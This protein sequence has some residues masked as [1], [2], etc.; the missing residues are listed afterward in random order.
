M[1]FVYP[2]FLLALGTLAIPILIHLFNFRRYKK[3]WF[4]NVQFLKEIQ[5]ETRKQSRL[6]QFLIL[7]ARLLAFACLVL[8][9]SQPYIPAPGQQQ[10]IK[11]PRAVSIYI[12]NS[13]S[14]EAVAT[15]GK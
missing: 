7:M 12:D 13:F 11:G 2:W 3:V 15:E 14:M 1:Q 4:T 9:F 6:R 10:R 8:A 5:Q